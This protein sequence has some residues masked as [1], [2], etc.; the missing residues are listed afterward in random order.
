MTDSGKRAK[1]AAKG[2]DVF[3]DNGQLS[4]VRMAEGLRDLQGTMSE[5]DFASFTQ[6]LFGTQGGRGATAL[7]SQL[8][9]M[10]SAIKEMDAA[11]A[12]AGEGDSLSGLVATQQDGFEGRV[13]EMQSALE[14]LKIELFDSGFGKAAELGA[15][16]IA[17][18]ASAFTTL[19]GA[20]PGLGA[21][22]GG[23]A[24]IAAVVGPLLLAVGFIG[25]ALGQGFAI[26]TA[27]AGVIKGVLVGVAAAAAGVTA[28]IL[29]IVA[30]VAAVGFAIYKFWPAIQAYYTGIAQGFSSAMDSVCGLGNMFATAFA[31]LTEA[32]APAIDAVSSALG[33]LFTQSDAGVGTMFSL[34]QAV[35]VGLGTALQIVAS[36]ISL[37]VQMFVIVGQAIGTELGKVFLFAT[38][39]AYAFTPVVAM[40]SSLGATIGAAFMSLGAIIMPA[41]AMIGAAFQGLVTTIMA[42]AT[43]IGSYLSSAFTS[44]IS[45]IQAAVT[46]IGA[47]FGQLPGVINGMVAQAVGVIQGAAGM[48]MSAGVGLMTALANGIKSAIGKVISTV[49]GAVSQI[50]GLLPFSPA[51][52]GPL[53]DLDKTGPALL[54]TFAA[55][56]TDRPLVKALTPALGKAADLLRPQLSG[57][58]LQAVVDYGAK[59]ANPAQSA[60]AAAPR[61]APPPAARGPAQAAPAP[62]GGSAPVIN[63]NFSPTINATDVSGVEQSLSDLEDRF[64]DMVQRAIAEGQR[65]AY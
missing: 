30:A 24:A 6:D 21:F 59:L 40:F 48:F 7:V 17:K 60:V 16:A 47:A 46:S 61:V 35:G 28:P 8:D 34:G 64:R 23:I 63:L 31:P 15:V 56:I 54:R 36:A 14:G 20:V 53:S 58:P 5:A 38:Q 51:K 26:A 37:V 32:L 25:P 43:A 2:I 12:G 39:I 65:L 27:A 44:A 49:S 3:G 18:L 29:A 9:K 52:Y 13:A 1:L 57:G 11:E 45:V 50:R 33:G 4:M 42:I 41:I 62:S 22:L 19:I 10:K 55:G